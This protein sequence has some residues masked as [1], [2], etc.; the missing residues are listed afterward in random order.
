VSTPQ[1]ILIVDDDMDFA[2]VA[3]AA[4][5]AAGYRVVTAE[6]AE[7]G[8][9]TAIAERPDVILLDLMMEETDSGVRLA[10]QLRRDATTQA[11]PIVILTAVRQATGFDFTPTAREDYGWIGADAWIEK[12]IAPRDLV[13]LAA[14]LLETPRKEG[15]AA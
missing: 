5:E 15:D 8:L 4:L 6:D 13:Q 11:T 14:R 1:T 3:G 12:P 2:A 7:R 9:E 10:H